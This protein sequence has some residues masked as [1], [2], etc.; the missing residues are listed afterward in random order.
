MSTFNRF[1]AATTQYR[2]AIANIVLAAVCAALGA[3]ALVFGYVIAGLLVLVVS[4]VLAW[5]SDAH[6]R[7]GDRIRGRA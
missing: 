1:D 4:G 2:W 5:N 6:K 3:I 7:R